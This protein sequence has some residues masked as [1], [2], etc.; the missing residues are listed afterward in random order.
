MRPYLARVL[1]TL[2]YWYEQQGRSAEAEQ[3]RAEVHQLMEE[4][5]LPPVRPLSSEP[6]GAD[7]PHLSAEAADR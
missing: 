5:P 2:I 4:L 3:A 7:E 6:L 1:Q